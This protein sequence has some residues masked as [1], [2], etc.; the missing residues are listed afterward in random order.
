MAARLQNT[1]YDANGQ[2]WTIII[3]DADY[4]G[5]AFDIDITAAK[6]QWQ[7]SSSER[8]APV[9]PSVADIGFRVNGAIENA[10]VTDYIAASEQRFKLIIYKGVNVFWVGNIQTDNVRKED[11]EYPYIFTIRAADGLALL[12]DIE[13][14]DD[15][16]PYEGTQTLAEHLA[17]AL[18]KA[19]T[20]AFLSPLLAVKINWYSDRFTTDTDVFD[21]TSLDHR[22]F[23]QVD[24][25]GTK[26]YN[27]CYDVIESICEA[28]GA[29]I[30]MTDGCFRIVQLNE[31]EGGSL[32]FLHYDSTGS[33]SG[34]QSS[35]SYRLT[36]GTD[37]VRIGG[38]SFQY[39][40]A[41]RKTEVRFTHFQAQSIIPPNGL[42]TVIFNVDNIDSNAGTN[43]LLI[44]SEYQAQTTFAT[45]YIS[46][47]IKFGIKVKVG[48]LYLSRTATLTGPKS[49]TYGDAVWT[50]V[51]SFIEFYSVLLTEGSNNIYTSTQTFLSPYIPEDG[52]LEI[53]GGLLDVVDINGNTLIGD[54]SS[55]L[56]FYNS[57]VEVVVEGTISERQ[58]ETV[59]TAENFANDN[60]RTV[61]K[62]VEIGQAPSFNALGA[63][64]VYSGINYF[65]PAGWAV[66]AT[67]VDVPLGKL[68]ANEILK[69]QATPVQII[70]ASYIGS[71]S[72]IN[73]IYHDSED[74]AVRQ[75]TLDLVEGKTQGLFFEC[76][77]TGAVIIEKDPEPVFNPESEPIS[78]IT[79][80]GDIVKD[81]NAEAEIDPALQSTFDSIKVFVTDQ[82]ISA[83]DLVSS[84]QI[85]ASGVDYLIKD[86]DEF[87]VIDSI[88]GQV[89]VFTATADVLA[90]DTTVSVQSVTADYD[91]VSGSNIS[92]D[93]EQI[94]IKINENSSGG[95]GAVSSLTGGQG[96]DVNV[97]TGD[98]T[99]SLDLTELPLA[100]FGFDANDYI[101]GNNGSSNIQGTV[102]SMFQ[103][104]LSAGSN[105]T[106]T[107]TA[108]GIQI[109]ATV[110]TSGVDSISVGDGLDGGGTGTV[111][112]VLDLSELPL[113]AGYDYNDY[114]VGTTSTGTE[115]RTNVLDMFANMI[116]AGSNISVSNTGTQIQ[117][118]ASSSTYSWTVRGEDSN[119]EVITNGEVLDVI[120]GNGLTTTVSGGNLSIFLSGPGLIGLGGIDGDYQAWV[121]DGIITGR[122]SLRSILTDILTSSDGSVTIGTSGTSVN[123][124]ASGGGGTD[125]D[126]NWDDASVNL[127]YLNVDMS[128]T[129][130]SST[131]S[132]KRHFTIGAS[133]TNTATSDTLIILPSASS[134]YQ[135][136]QVWVAAYDN[137]A[138][139][140]VRITSGSTIKTLVN[141]ELVCVRC[142]RLA[143]TWTWLAT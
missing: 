65:N 6:I 96:I 70:A 141:A 53:S 45:G 15:G 93:Q 129:V 35:A 119:T 113:S 72:P 80:I 108:T 88:T 126:A 60:S 86:G 123:L 42:S 26:T 3:D 114:L 105:I 47:R 8:F 39:Y 13:Y 52:A 121:F 133:V 2:D 85:V 51:E 22:R 139:Y 19:G 62:K 38:G 63:L 71:I 115:S 61:E 20:S 112:I 7:A 91:I 24:T 41:L 9:V 99:A 50:N 59:Y 1:I 21:F 134:T 30:M 137:S 109:S 73:T 48:S 132:N 135:H 97:T 101:A 140:S 10:F 124:T 12:K 27:N 131:Y 23:I 67:G 110:P 102:L 90:S 32:D 83:G 75:A 100:G 31:Y 25:T 128:S 29:R 14:N 69:T 64:Q 84:V 37:V 138:S 74:Y 68:L 122:R 79:P 136:H 106:L 34:S 107:T 103:N 142:L 17:N 92:F 77:S 78:P 98:V 43:K 36:D 120:A 44:Q 117:I 143:G 28:F 125:G 40:P 104:L 57:Y 5:S 56:D 46:N 76:S 66:G 58:N 18:S 95:G 81:P 4:T 49:V 111:S 11:K 118:S 16:T 116:T 130:I 54:Y 94:I 55:N 33:P 87:Q 82:D 127:Q 89:Q